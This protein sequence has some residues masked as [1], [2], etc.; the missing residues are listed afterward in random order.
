MNVEV[1]FSAAWMRQ[2]RGRHHSNIRL[3][4]MSACGAKRIRTALRKVANDLNQTF[5]IVVTG[6]SQVLNWAMCKKTTLHL[7][8]SQHRSRRGRYLLKQRFVW[9]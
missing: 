2:R 5:M 9:L 8:K 3:W 6:S 7:P 4:W 1:I